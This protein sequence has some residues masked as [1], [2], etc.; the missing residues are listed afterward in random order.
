MAGLRSYTAIAER[1]T[2]IPDT[3][4]LALG[5]APDRRS[6]EAMIRRLLQ[7][8]DRTCSPQPSAAGSPREPRSHQRAG[9][10]SRWTARRC[11]PPAPPTPPPVMS[12]PHV[13]RPFG[14]IA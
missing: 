3:T 4:A 10:R 13:T 8:L 2:D 9:G 11:E 6:S 5:I 12:S 14:A 7:A 1:V